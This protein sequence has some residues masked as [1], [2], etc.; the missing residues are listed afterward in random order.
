[1]TR[2]VEGVD[3]RLSDE[4]SRRFIVFS[5]RENVRAAVWSDDPQG[6]PLKIPAVTRE[7]QV[8]REIILYR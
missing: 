8:P 6:K 1:M 2:Y 4:I 5:A 3:S 7:Q